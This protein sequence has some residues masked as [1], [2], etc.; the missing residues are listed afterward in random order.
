MGG[1]LPPHGIVD[2]WGPKGGE[3][4]Q[5]TRGFAETAVFSSKT[6]QRIAKGFGIVIVYHLSIGSRDPVRILSSYIWNFTPTRTI[7]R[8][9]QVDLLNILAPTPDTVPPVKLPRKTSP[10][11]SPRRLI[12]IGDGRVPYTVLM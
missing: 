11:T 9:P 4:A 10:E 12:S 3:Y 6:L 2:T 8:G 7:S 1:G 5:L